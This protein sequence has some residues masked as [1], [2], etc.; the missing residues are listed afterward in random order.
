ME[1]LILALFHYLALNKSD[2]ALYQDNDT[3]FIIAMQIT[4]ATLQNIFKKEYL[5]STRT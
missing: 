2:I 4:Y 3:Q 5:S 1:V